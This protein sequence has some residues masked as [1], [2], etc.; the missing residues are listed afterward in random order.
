LAFVNI[1]FSG[2]RA[3]KNTG[4]GQDKKINELS[5]VLVERRKAF[6]DQ[7]II[8]GEITVFQILDNVAR[9]STQLQKVA[10]QISE[11]GG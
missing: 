4:S 10:I 9:I 3:L 7:A 2:K 8:T 6:F 1:L 11:V 5:G